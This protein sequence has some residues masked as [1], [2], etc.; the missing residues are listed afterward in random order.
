MDLIK[1]LQK[2]VMDPQWK[3][4]VFAF[5]TVNGV[6]ESG[7][8]M[9]ELFNMAPVIRGGFGSE[10]NAP[11][12]TRVIQKATFSQELPTL[13]ELEGATAATVT[14]ESVGGGFGAT[15]YEFVYGRLVRASC[16]RRRSRPSAPPPGP[17]TKY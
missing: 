4:W 12:H 5:G 13:G 17:W 16:W 8:T 3:H 7:G 14:H 9:S 2:L 6:L 15:E 10:D 1:Q 11:E